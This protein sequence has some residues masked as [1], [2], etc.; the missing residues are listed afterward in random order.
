MLRWGF[1]LLLP[2][3][4]LCHILSKSLAL[5]PCL[6]DCRR[7]G[8]HAG[9]GERTAPRPLLLCCSVTPSFSNALSHTLKHYRCASQIVDLRQCGG[10]ADDELAIAE[11]LRARQEKRD[12]AKIVGRAA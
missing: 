2:P 7:A 5:P 11:N 9:C 8:K 3:L 6:T 1:L 10:D 12:R 4:H